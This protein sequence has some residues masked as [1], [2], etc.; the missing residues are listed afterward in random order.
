MKKKN[1]LLLAFGLVTAL[2]TCAQWT[3][4]N[5]QDVIRGVFGTANAVIESSDLN[6]V[7]KMR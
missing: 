2:P 5:T 3:N 4:F 1:V 6:K 7:F